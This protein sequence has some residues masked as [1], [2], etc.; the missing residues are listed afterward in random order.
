MGDCEQTE[1]CGGG[2]PWFPLRKWWQS[3]RLF[4]QDAG[5]PPFLEPG[6]PRWTDVDRLQRGLAGCS[7]PGYIP[8]PLF[9][10]YISGPMHQPGQQSSKEPYKWRV[11]LEV[12]HFFPSEISLSVRGGFL[13]VRGK[14]EERPDEHG[15]I[16]RCFTR[17]YR[18]PAEMDTS[19][20]ISMLSVD[21]ILTVEA[22][23]S[24]TFVASAVILPIQVELQ[25]T[26]EK[27]EKEEAPET[28]VENC[29]APEAQCLPPA[30]EHE[31]QGDRAEAQQHDETRQPEEESHEEP[32]GETGP[33]ASEAGEESAGLRDP[34]EHR[35]V[36]TGTSKPPE[37]TEPAVDGEIRV[38]T[39]SVEEEIDHLQGPGP[40]ER[41]PSEGPSQE[42]EP[43]DAK[44]ERTE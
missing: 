1:S 2:V 18:L 19:K 14:H 5:L 26:G 11:S 29:G 25:V 44:Q 4:N 40:G 36:P 12:A 22:P 31:L 38:T 3:S 37:R 27:L 23:V 9:V 41:P 15:F 16:A 39:G 17:K 30:E 32:A 33:P 10:P 21:G 6:D 43:V 8:A 35:E 7:W 34:P 13:E 28:E 24:K 42:L 20:I